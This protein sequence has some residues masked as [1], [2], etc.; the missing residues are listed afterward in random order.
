MATSISTSIPTS[1]PVDLESD[2]AVVGQVAC[3][4]VTPS[5]CGHNSLLIGRIGDWTWQ[6]VGDA[7][8]VDVLTARNAEGQPTYLSFCYYRVVGSRR[9]H[10]RSPEF[11]DRLDVRSGV[12]SLGSE[13]VVVLHELRRRGP[14]GPLRT[15][16]VDPAEFFRF[17]DPDCLYVEHYNRWVSRGESGSNN[18]LVQSSPAGFRHK[19]L[20]SLP[21]PYS[22]RIPFRRALTTG[23]P[24]A[25]PFEVVDRCGLRFPVDISR[26]LNGAGLLYFASYFSIADRALLS[27]WRH[28]GWDTTSFLDR[29]VLDQQMCLQGNADADTMLAVE[30]SWGNVADG[31]RPVEVTV[32]DGDT[33][34]AIA[35]CALELLD[36]PDPEESAR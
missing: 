7:C 15:E 14:G 2:S 24:R 27:M 29:V 25:A 22:P 3:H 31:S 32:T 33:G 23:T 12:F 19:H 18:A 9:F 11:G 4:L 21:T 34:R 28:Q 8:D 6:L 10:L 36:T 20:P 13:S 35:V 26:D 30:V 17:D 16:P 5:M 1:A